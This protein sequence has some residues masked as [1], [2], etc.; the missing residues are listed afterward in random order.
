VPRFGA[1][2]GMLRAGHGV[3]DRLAAERGVVIMLAGTPFGAAGTA[4]PPG[5]AGTRDA[6]HSGRTG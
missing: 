5:I 1:S 4:D 3:L 2:L 6:A